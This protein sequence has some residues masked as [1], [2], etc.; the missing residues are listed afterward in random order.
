M[1][2]QEIFQSEYSG[3]P[4]ALPQWSPHTCFWPSSTDPNVIHSKQIHLVPQNQTY[5]TV[6]IS[7]CMFLIWKAYLWESSTKTG[8]PK[9][10]HWQDTGWYSGNVANLP[11]SLFVCFLSHYHLKIHNF[12]HH[13]REEGMSRWDINELTMSWQLLNLGDRYFGTCYSV[14][15]T[16]VN[17]LWSFKETL[18]PCKDM[19]MIFRYEG[20]VI[21]AHQSNLGSESRKGKEK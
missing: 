6:F 18:Y 8:T 21:S 12:S 3:A 19:G 11:S 10:E 14:L 17:F 9:C 15:C 16:Y 1:I 2:V 5:M 7:H 20:R 4:E 13:I